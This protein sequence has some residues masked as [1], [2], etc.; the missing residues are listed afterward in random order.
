MPEDARCYSI[1]ATLN[2]VWKRYNK[3]NES[4]RDQSNF[5]ASL[6]QNNYRQKLEVRVKLMEVKDRARERQTDCLI[7]STSSMYTL[8]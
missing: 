5:P 7:L 3:L 2:S 8:V 1:I 6:H 4:V